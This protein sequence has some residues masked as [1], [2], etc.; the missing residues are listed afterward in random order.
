MKV[1]LEKLQEKMLAGCFNVQTLSDA[2]G[3]SRSTVSRALNRGK[4]ACN[5][6]SV[7]KIARAL[8]CKPEEILKK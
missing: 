1:D 6:A 4:G 2:A 8:R 5:M 7:G 3:V